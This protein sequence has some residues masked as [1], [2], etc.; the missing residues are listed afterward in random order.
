MKGYSFDKVEKRFIVAHKD[1][2]VA[3]YHSKKEAVEHCNQLTE[4]FYWGDMEDIHPDY[5]RAFGYRYRP[6]KGDT[7]TY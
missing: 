4:E 5:A 1:T 7:W 2:V 3:E 6:S